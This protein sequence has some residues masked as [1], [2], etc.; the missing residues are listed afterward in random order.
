MRRTRLPPPA[1]VAVYELTEWGREC[2]PIFQALG[3][4]AARSP[5]HD[6]TLPISAN[7]LMLSFR[8]MFDRNRAGDL[9]ASVA[10]RIGDETFR[11]EVRD[12][13]ITVCRA[14]ED[15]AD[16]TFTGP[17]AAIGAFVYGGLPPDKLPDLIIAGDAAL[18]RRF[19]GLFPLPPK[20]ASP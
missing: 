2:E 16:L 19:A 20:V 5:C 13:A 8:T 18:A 12:G 9:S 3:R 17:A 15:A 14:A 7:S 10:F 4:W 1:S 11:A 6:P